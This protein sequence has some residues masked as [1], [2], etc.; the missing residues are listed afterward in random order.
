[1]N[2]IYNKNKTCFSIDCAN[3]PW[4][5]IDFGSVNMIVK[6]RDFDES[7]LDL[8][9]PWFGTKYARTDIPTA[10]QVACKVGCDIY[11][12]V[13]VKSHNLVYK[14]NVNLHL[15]K[16][17]LLIL[18]ILLIRNW[19]IIVEILKQKLNMTQ[20]NARIPRWKE[21]STCLY[22]TSSSQKILPLR[23]KIL[24]PPPFLWNSSRTISVS[25]STERIPN[26]C[27]REPTSSTTYGPPFLF[28]R[29]RTAFSWTCWPT[30]SYRSL[31]L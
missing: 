2:F 27:S 31:C 24:P 19:S 3:F 26:S 16:K 18:G 6:S 29:W 5:I 25:S 9:E 7:S 8:V 1:M 17:K 10:W 28:S 30:A 12:L 21:S 22:Q 14:K 15:I 20:P 11:K 13:D 23:R 4:Y